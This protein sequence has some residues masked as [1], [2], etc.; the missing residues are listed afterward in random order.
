MPFDSLLEAPPHVEGKKDSTEKRRYSFLYGFM[1]PPPPVPDSLKKPFKSMFSGNVGFQAGRLIYYDDQA[2]ENR[3][4]F[5]GAFSATMNIRLYKEL[6]ISGTFFGNLNRQDLPPW[7]SEFFYSVKWFNW[8]PNTF[9]LGYENYADNRYTDNW[10]D[11]SKKFLIGFYFV[12]FNNNLPQKWIEKIRIDETTN[13]NITYMVRYA[14][15]FRDAD[16]N[17]IGGPGKVILTLSM[18]YTIAKRLFLEGAAHYYPIKDTKVPWDPD[19]TYGFGY[20]DYR[21]WRVS[22]TYGNWIANRFPWNDKGIPEYNFLDGIFSVNF[23]Y[24]FP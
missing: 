24:Q 19:F 11:F 21:P 13:F 2:M 17:Y 15:Q 9:S 3:T 23:N 14:I 18:R 12:S 16:N 7:V 8:R 10:H 6:M 22:V 4:R 20:F 1:Q 5:R